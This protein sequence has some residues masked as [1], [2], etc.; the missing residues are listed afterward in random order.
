MADK[1]DRKTGEGAARVRAR[2]VLVDL[3]GAQ[4]LSDAG[5]VERAL[6]DAAAAAGA[7]V[8]GLELRRFGDGGGVSGVALLAESHMSVHTWPEAGFAAIDVFLC[9]AADPDRAVPVLTKAF[10]PARVSTSEHERGRS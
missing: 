5:R 10:A 3:W 2:H 9:G 6:R 4:G 1:A 8:I 7:T